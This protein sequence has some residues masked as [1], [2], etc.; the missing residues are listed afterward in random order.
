MDKQILRSS[1]RQA[2]LQKALVRSSL[3]ASFGLAIFLFSFFTLAP[4]NFTL[5][6]LLSYLAGTFFI[7]LGFIPYRRLRYLEL[8]PYVLELDQTS[9]TFIQKGKA[10]QCVAWTE[11]I[12]VDYLDTSTVYGIQLTL[13]ANQKILLPYFSQRSYEALQSF[14]SL[15]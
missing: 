4:H 8:N 11:I 3:F 7:A 13:H 10:P 2:L 5:L 9:L 1:I 6:G 15:Q 12:S 14:R